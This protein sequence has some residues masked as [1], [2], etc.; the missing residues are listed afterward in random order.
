MF[1]W[2]VLLAVL[3]LPVSAQAE[4]RQAVSRHFIV[5]SEGSEQ[6]I[7][8]AASDLERYDRLLRLMMDAPDDDPVKVKIYLMQNMGQVQRTMGPG[9]GRSGVAG[10]Y[11]ASTRGPIAVGLRQDTGGSKFDLT[12]EVVLFHEYAH[13]LMMR[14]FGS[15][16]PSWY[17]EG[18][19]EFYGM[20]RMLPNNVIETGRPASHRLALMR[21]INEWMPLK[22][23]LSATTWK[24]LDG[25]AYLVYSQGWLLT[26]YL[27]DNQARK[28]Q[29]GRYLTAINRGVD[30]KTAMDQAFGPDAAEL[31]KELRLYSRKGIFEATRVTFPPF[32][33][34]PIRIR[35]LGKAESELLRHDIALS[36]GIY[37]REAADFV[38][39]VREI[40]SRFPNDAYAAAILTEAEYLT[41]NRTAAREAAERW[42]ALEPAAP[43]ALMYMS[44]I[45]A[46]ELAKAESDDK[47][48]WA[49]PIRW[50]TQ[51]RDAAPT[52]SLVLEAYYD[53]HAAQGSLPPARAQNALYRA[54]ELVPQ[55]SG[56]RHKVA[57]DFERRGL[58]EAAILAIRPAAY[59]THDPDRETEKEKIKRERWEEKWRRAGT[60]KVES[61]REMLA[62]LEA[63]LAAEPSPASSET[64]AAD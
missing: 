51:A 59:R 52:D 36:R 12:S 39:E 19:A 1:R 48:R 60:E 11:S 27:A 10:Y 16:Y 58:I 18:F 61:P 26:H 54:M 6:E 47:T 5:Y 13:H 2:F 33:M 53:V 22:Q 43:R 42:L 35:T 3:C 29:L 41:D 31:N 34:G 21:E 23:M 63:K 49:R 40:A 45:E 44:L 24:E 55:D 14:H 9:G 28:G 37:A 64:A 25:K 57:G 56:L 32:E 7:R 15:A 46:S 20:T 30:R 4:W 62:R 38:K 17:V 50:I 8:Q